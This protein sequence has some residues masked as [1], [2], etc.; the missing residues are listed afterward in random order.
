M[1]GW[2][3]EQVTSSTDSI[4][5]LERA[6]DSAVEAIGEQRDGRRKAE[7]H[8][9]GFITALN[10]EPLAAVMQLKEERMAASQPFCTSGGKW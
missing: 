10:T 3:N 4:L 1:Y 2:L 5:S 8:S 7:D 9:G 6:A